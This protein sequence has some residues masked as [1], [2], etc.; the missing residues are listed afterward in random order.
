MFAQRPTY[1]VRSQRTIP[2]WRSSFGVIGVTVNAL[3]IAHSKNTETITAAAVAVCRGTMD[4]APAD[5][6]EGILSAQLMAANEASV[7]MYS[8]GWAQP[9]EYFQARTGAG[10]PE[11]II[12][13]WRQNGASAVTAA[14]FPNCP[15]CQSAAWVRACGVGQIR[16]MFSPIPPR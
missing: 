10:A 9:P 3:P 13:V 2:E 6:V 5:P 12:R 8:K 4:I 11:L 16:T 15:S 14:L 7:A 1:V